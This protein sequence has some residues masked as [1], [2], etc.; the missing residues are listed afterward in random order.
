MP[1]NF[2]NRYQTHLD[3][4]VTNVA[5]TGVV[6]S[7]TG[8]PAVPFRAIISAE[9][10]NT[11]EIVLVTGRV[12]TTLTWTRAAEAVAGVQVAS[13]HGDGALF[14]AIVTAAGLASLD[15][16]ILMYDE[17]AR[18]PDGALSGLVP[19]VGPTWVGTGAQPPTVA[20]GLLT[21][22][23]VGYAL[24][25]FAEQVSYIEALVVF[26][27]TDDG[28][29]GFSFGWGDDSVANAIH[30]TVGGTGAFTLQLRKD[31]GSFDGILFANS[32]KRR[33]AFDGVTPYKFAMSL[34]GETVVVHGPGG[35]VF[36]TTDARIPELAGADVFWEPLT[37]TYVSKLASVRALA[38]P[39][40]EVALTNGPNAFDLTPVGDDNLYAF[41]DQWWHMEI[42]RHTV[43]DLPAIT[44]G[45]LRIRTALVNAIG[46]GAV[47][48]TTR[49]RLFNGSTILG[50]GN[51]AET[52][53]VSGASSSAPWTAT[54]TAATK[55]HAAGEY[56]EGGG[57]PTGLRPY[58]DFNPDSW[59]STFHGELNLDNR[60]SINNTD[61]VKARHTGWTAA[62]GSATR[63]TFA[64]TTV[65]TEQL[66]ERVKALLDDLIDHG[67]IGS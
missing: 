50:Y 59:K 15:A 57:N 20:S 35:E 51:D 39:T 31:S 25:S 43:S 36:A 42:G 47:A 33:I 46:I 12:G 52:V 3:G 60:L 5:L 55:A 13:A 19:L 16:R 4:A 14:T 29:E 53:T 56:V 6:E 8:I 54:I 10:A 22:S 44:F 7:V 28:S 34:H 11:N 49:D 2:A 23:G 18:H 67:L 1:E 45:P 65:T 38:R 26:S 64:T 48:I 30:L 37:G 61:V 41:R 27:G 9:G 62:T 66:A 17:F 63:T 21:S 58:L 40:N 24:G 32:W